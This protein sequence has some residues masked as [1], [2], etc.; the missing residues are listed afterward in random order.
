MYSGEPIQGKEFYYLLVESDEFTSELGRMTLAS[1]MLE[2][3]IIKYFKRSGHDLY[4]KTLTFGRLIGFG[5]KHDLFLSNELNALDML[6]AQRNEF[7]HRIYS[8]FIGLM[9]EERL[10]TSNLL[11]SDISTYIEYAWQLKDN[12]EGMTEIIIKK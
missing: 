9:Q 11:D 4:P 10:P 3:E 6:N 5:K 1:G 2:A 7:T 12:L 8:L